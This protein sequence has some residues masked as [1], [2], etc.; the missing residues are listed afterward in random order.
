MQF[1]D[2]H[3]HLDFS[4]YDSD[5]D[6]LI[7]RLAIDQIGVIN[8]AT[9]LESNQKINALSKDNRFIWG[10]V[11]LHPTEITADV[12]KKLPS[13]L[14]Q[15]ERI[16][17]ENSKIVAVGEIGLDYFHDYS[18]ESA[19]RQKTALRQFL[20]FAQQL[21]L[22]VIIHCRDAY[23]DMVTILEDYKGLKGV[24]HCFSGSIEQAREFWR[25]GF[26]TSF[27]AMITYP[28]NT[29]LLEIIKQMPKSSILL[30][31]DSPFLPI[32]Q[33]RGK[34][35]EPYACNAVAGV[36]AKHKSLDFDKVIEWSLK[37][38]TALFN[39]IKEN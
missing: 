11:G 6:E 1:I 2:T 39:R 9:D 32:W 25:L 34:R 21:K 16:V 4:A 17:N 27:T 20:T 33:L 15:L 19:N 8:V 7:L 3:A 13:I 12:L 30:E 37:N 23:G 28:K 29:H 14:N 24:V 38:T 10:T 22:P 5:R 36:I 35:N 31:T 18:E 26:L